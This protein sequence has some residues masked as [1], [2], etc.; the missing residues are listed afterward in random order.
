[1]LPVLSKDDCIKLFEKIGYPS[2]TS[3]GSLLGMFWWA[4]DLGRDKFNFDF[5]FNRD[6]LSILDASD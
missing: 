1:M 6:D 5:D 2:S 4:A 3:P